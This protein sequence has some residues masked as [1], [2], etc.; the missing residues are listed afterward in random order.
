[1]ISPGSVTGSCPKKN[2]KPSMVHEISVGLI[3]V[4]HTA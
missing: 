3:E 2:G 1:M 4:A